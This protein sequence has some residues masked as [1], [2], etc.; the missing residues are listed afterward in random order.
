VAK[1]KTTKEADVRVLA[2]R[3]DHLPVNLTEPEIREAGKRLAQLEGAVGEHTAKE[4][5]V[6]DRLKSERSVYEGQISQIASVIR[7]GHEYR[8]VSV[9]VEAHFT[10]GKVREIREDNG[11]VIAERAIT[12]SDRQESLRLLTDP[13][14]PIGLDLAEADEADED[15]PI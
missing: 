10:D 15:L 3:T 9:R 8:P 11:A 4:K 1:K 5:E 13:E 2:V 7:Q 6:K 14:E 12:E